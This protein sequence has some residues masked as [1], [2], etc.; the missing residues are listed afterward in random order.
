MPKEEILPEFKFRPRPGPGPDPATWILREILDKVGQVEVARL[1]VEHEI[2]VN[3]AEA[4]YLL[5]IQKL[6]NGQK[7]SG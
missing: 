5:G 1:L 6:A 3:A 2:A 7:S 4:A